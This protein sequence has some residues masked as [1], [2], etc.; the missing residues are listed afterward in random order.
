MLQTWDSLSE[1]WIKTEILGP[2][3]TTELCHN[4]LPASPT[5]C[6]DIMRA[7]QAVWQ[8]VT[9]KDS[10][11]AASQRLLSAEDNAVCSLYMPHVD[12][13]L[14]FRY[15]R[16]GETKI[17]GIFFPSFSF[18][19]VVSPYVF[20]FVSYRLQPAL[21]SPLISHP[22]ASWHLLHKHLT[23]ENGLPV[24]AQCVHTCN[25]LSSHTLSH[26]HT[27]THTRPCTEACAISS[28]CTEQLDGQTVCWLSE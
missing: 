12:F 24:W 15:V 18:K 27:H 16:V 5:E 13:R 22:W 19:F 8:S 9:T 10:P 14:F 17:D 25:P 23:F 2:A 1:N 3:A 4:A 28:L 21:R 6:A 20:L 7:M 26:T 11:P